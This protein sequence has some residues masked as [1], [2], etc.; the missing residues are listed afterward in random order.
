[1]IAPRVA[2]IVGD[3]LGWDAAHRDEEVARY[4]EGAHREFDVPPPA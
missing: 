3:V 1:V 4:L 2:E